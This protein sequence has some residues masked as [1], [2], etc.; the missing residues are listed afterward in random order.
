[1]KTLLALIVTNMAWAG[2]AFSEGFPID[3]PVGHLMAGE[4][5]THDSKVIQTDERGYVIC[6]DFLPTRSGK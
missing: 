4:S 5:P 2:Y 3:I 1:M 6:S